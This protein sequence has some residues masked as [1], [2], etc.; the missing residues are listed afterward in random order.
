MVRAVALRPAPSSKPNVALPLYVAPSE[1]E[2]LFSWMLRLA[3]R[4]RCSMHALASCTFGIDDRYGH[5]RW[6]CRPHPWLLKRISERTG[7]EVARLRTMTFEGWAPIYRDDEDSGR[8]S[9]RRYDRP[10]PEHRTYRFVVCGQCLE[11]D[12]KPYLRSSWLIGWMAVCPIHGTQLI[13]RCSACGAAPRVAPFANTTI[14]S[15]GTCARCSKSLLGNA[16]LTAHPSVVSMQAVLLEGKRRGVFDLTGLGSLTWKEMVALADVLLGTVWGDITLAEK[17]ELLHA[18]ASD[19]LQE[20]PTL[21]G[22]FD[23]RH[24]SLLFLA[25]LIS[26]WPDSPGATVAH[27]LLSRWL[28]AERNRLCRHLHPAQEDPWTVGPNN[29]ESPIRER[30]QALAGAG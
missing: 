12:A 16:S 15:P 20:K 9:G 3:T 19:A 4:L 10:A 29:F 7:V 24:A 8:F 23:R 2:A 11:G 6:W 1:D 28:T 21:D 18:F 30:L 27:H 14:F 5:S 26:G 25:W 13:D 22:I 17:E